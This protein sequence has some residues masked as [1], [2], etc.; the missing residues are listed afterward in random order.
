MAAR[1]AGQ[2]ASPDPATAHLRPLPPTAPGEYHVGAARPQF[3]QGDAD[4]V[5]AADTGT[6]DRGDQALRTA[7]SVPSG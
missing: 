7:S 2:P 6:A 5:M 4:R 1:V 3:A